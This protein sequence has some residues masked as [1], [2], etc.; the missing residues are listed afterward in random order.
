MVVPGS[1]GSGLCMDVRAEWRDGI[2][3]D[4]RALLVLI[5]TRDMTTGIWN[6]EPY[7]RTVLRL[8]TVCVTNI[9]YTPSDISLQTLYTHTPH[10]LRSLHHGCQVLDNSV[11]SSL[12]FDLGLG[13]K[14]IGLMDSASV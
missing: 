5:A 3:V 11:L 1:A 13:L 10:T 14:V 8:D 7:E 2:A 12:L 9:A 6:V 4:S